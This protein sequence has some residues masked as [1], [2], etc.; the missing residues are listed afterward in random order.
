MPQTHSSTS[1][2]GADS[3]SVVVACPSCATRFRFHPGEHPQASRGSCSVCAADFELT[4]R[5]CSYRVMNEPSAPSPEHLIA[6]IPIRPAQPDDAPGLGIGMDDPSLAE[7]VMAPRPEI[8]APVIDEPIEALPPGVA[9]AVPAGIPAPE[10]GVVSAVPSLE[11]SVESEPEIAEEDLPPAQTPVSRERPRGGALRKLGTLA[12][13]ALALAATGYYASPAIP[14]AWRVSRWIPQGL[15]WLGGEANLTAA[16]GGLCGLCLGV[17]L[18][19][20]L[21]RK[22]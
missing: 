10:G 11:S 22:S 4:P 15:G 18:T 6:S 8:D 7:R 1:A 17:A 16:A 5:R 3:A 12:L 20:W 19:V 13:P 14:A 9:E 2:T 21:S